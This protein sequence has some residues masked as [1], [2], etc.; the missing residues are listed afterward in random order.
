MSSPM[1]AAWPSRS[2]TNRYA[3]PALA[4]PISVTQIGAPSS[5][6]AFMIERALSTSPIEQAGV[7]Q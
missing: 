4:Q 7:S 2:V 3:L 1:L 5:P 6:W